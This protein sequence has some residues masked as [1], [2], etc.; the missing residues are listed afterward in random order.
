MQLLIS[1]IKTVLELGLT[2]FVMVIIYRFL[3]RFSLHPVCA[4]KAETPIGPFF[5]KSRLPESDLPTLE[6]WTS[7]A[8]LFSHLDVFFDEPPKWL[9]T[10]SYTHL[11]LPTKA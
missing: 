3:I 5:E 6:A 7:S 9:K 1:R 11:T 2:E 8:T 10:V 4:I